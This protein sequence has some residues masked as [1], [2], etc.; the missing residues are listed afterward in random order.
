MA[1]IRETASVR[2]NFWLT[3]SDANKL[4]EMASHKDVSEAWIVRQLI[5]KAGVPDDGTDSET[6][7]ESDNA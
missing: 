6:P 2:K 1:R 7:E 4:A 5:R 3:P